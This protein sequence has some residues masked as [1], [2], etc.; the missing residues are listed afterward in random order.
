MRELNHTIGGCF[1]ISQEY[2]VWQYVDLCCKIKFFCDTRCE[3]THTHTTITHLSISVRFQSS[4][5]SQRCALQQVDD[6]RLLKHSI[7]TTRIHFPTAEKHANHEYLLLY[8]VGRV[9]VVTIFIHN[10]LPL[11]L[12]HVRWVWRLHLSTGKCDQLLSA[13]YRERKSEEER[14]SNNNERNITKAIAIT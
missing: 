13:R 4:R 10:V 2:F 8:S 6:V 1:V 7:T 3:P 11:Y 5:K 9:D 12:C 14:R